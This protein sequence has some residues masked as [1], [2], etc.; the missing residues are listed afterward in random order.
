M[1]YD[2]VI[3]DAFPES[4]PNPTPLPEAATPGCCPAW[5]FLAHNVQ[6]P[7]TMIEDMSENPVTLFSPWP[8]PEL[9]Y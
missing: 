4:L 6:I 8:G 1:K 5:S 9:A 7:T 2:C 3:L